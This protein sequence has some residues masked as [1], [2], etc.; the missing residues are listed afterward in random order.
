M[1]GMPKVGDVVRTPRFC[2]VRIGEV[3][4][5]VDAMTK[6]GYI[7]STYNEDGLFV[8]AGKTI[9]QYTMEFAVAPRGVA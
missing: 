5:S 6:A 8:I 4:V 3:F 7:Q 9:D 1:D 2:R